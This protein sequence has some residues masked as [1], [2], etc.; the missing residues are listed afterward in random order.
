LK[1]AKICDIVQRRDWG[2]VTLCSYI[3]ATEI[4]RYPWRA[5][6]RYTLGRSVGHG[7]RM[8]PP[9]MTLVGHK[10]CGSPS[11]HRPMKHWL[12]LERTLKVPGDYRTDCYAAVALK[13]RRIFP[14]NPFH[15][16]H[17][18]RPTPC[19]QPSSLFPKEENHGSS[20][21]PILS[22]RKQT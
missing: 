1:E 22:P 11:Q 16:P 21:Q 6:A 5:F 19:T 14:S 20:T 18:F 12:Q 17:T 13:S 10:S 2:R 8:Y 9:F 15:A 3:D 4:K 7:P